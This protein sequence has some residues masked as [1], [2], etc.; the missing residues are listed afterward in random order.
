MHFT[1][2]DSFKR[3]LHGACLA[4]IFALPVSGFA[5]EEEIWVI[6]MR[7][8]DTLAGISKRYLL[9]PND[10]MKLQQFNK[11]RL[12]RAMPVGTR[13]N[14]PAAWM[15]ISDVEAQVIATR[16][17]VRIERGGADFPAVVG[18]PVKV[19]DRISAA[20]GSS[21]TLKFPDD[22]TSSLH[23]NTKARIDMMR[24]VPATDLI[25]QRL[26]LDAGRIE[27][28]VTPRK[29]SSSQF[30]IQTPVAT[31]GVRGTKFRTSVDDTSRGEVLEGRVEAAGTGSA[32]PV[33]VA[34]GF[35]TIIPANGIPSQPIALLPPPDLSKNP[36][37]YELNR[38]VFG[39]VAIPNAE[40][41]RAL[42]ARDGTFTDV[43][44]EIVSK[45]PRVRT[46]VLPDGNYYLRIRGIAGN[47][48]EGMEGQFPFSVKA[49][50]PPPPEALLPEHDDTVPGGGALIISW[51]PEK[52]AA[53]YRF[54]VNDKEDF[55]RVLQSA[56]RTISLRFALP[57][58]KPGRYY[59]R[60]ASNRADGTAGPWGPVLQFVVGA[61]QPTPNVES[62][63]KTES[64]PK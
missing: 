35:A 46:S 37:A 64:P 28:A 21:V 18:A 24:G 38:P 33:P 19:G 8:G 47:R 7:Q 52:L 26:R 14:V 6:E 53:S 1:H 45:T 29:N 48:M 23:A 54:Q 44:A 50:S 51:A 12:D 57:N 34:A 43:V 25:A 42:V 61:S 49:G 41:Y 30:E 3:L 17:T 32:K 22:S 63:A 55:T 59:W 56:E 31:I 2:I 15:R 27:S 39:F 13:V 11:V 62:P 20:E 60:L 58:P 40:Q 10:W 16:G 9:N 5:A 36:T 4:I